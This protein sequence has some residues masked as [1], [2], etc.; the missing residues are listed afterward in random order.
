MT[1]H[2]WL[3]KWGTDLNIWRCY[4]RWVISISVILSSDGNGLF[5]LSRILTVPLYNDCN[6][7]VDVAEARDQTGR[8][9][10]I[11][12]GIMLCINIF[13]AGRDMW[14]QICQKLLRFYPILSYCRFC[15]CDLNVRWQNFW[16][17]SEG[18][19]RFSDVFNYGQEC[20]SQAETWTM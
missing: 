20:F 17:N 14:F 5:F 3:Y 10:V 11:W 19:G 8:Q 15:W 7:F 13:A 6:C 9:Y 2:W 1:N 18:S 12:D 16:F 4:P